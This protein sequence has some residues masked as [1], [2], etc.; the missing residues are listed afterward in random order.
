MRQL[1][2]EYRPKGVRDHLFLHGLA[3]L[4]AR[5]ALRAGDSLYVPREWEGDPS[6]RA[7]DG[8]D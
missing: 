3:I 5:Q 1:A 8:D 7:G 2:A 6:D 4:A